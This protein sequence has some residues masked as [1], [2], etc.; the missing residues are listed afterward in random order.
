MNDYFVMLKD[1]VRSLKNTRVLVGVALFCGL[2]IILNSFN[3]YLG[4]TL[5]I[6]FGFLA[7]AASCYFYGPYPNMLAAFVMDFIGYA[8]HPDGPYFPGYALNAM[9]IALIF[10]SF[11]YQQTIKLWKIVVARALIVVFV[12]MI[13]N[14]LWLSIMYGDSFFVLLGARVLKNVILFPV[15]VALLFSILKICERLRPS[16]KI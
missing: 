7:T 8:M 10:S 14:S 1:N 5:R 13:L 15:D 12:Y 2:Q 6:T 9:L 4:P 11:F 3:I 16:I